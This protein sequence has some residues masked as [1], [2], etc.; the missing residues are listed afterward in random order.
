MAL[1]K[2]AVPT[3]EL[4]LPLSKKKITFRPFLVKE[5][6]IL[7]MAMESGEKD[8]MERAVKQILN[9]CTITELDINTI[10]LVDVE[11]YFLNLRARSIGEV[12]DLKYKCENEVDNKKCGHLMETKVNLLEIKVDGLD[13]YKDIV[14][15]VDNIGIKFKYPEFS[16][17][18]KLNNVESASDVAFELIAG[19]I[20]YV[21]DGDSLNYANESTKEE[22]IAFLQSLDSKSFEK[23]DAYFENLPSMK[24][25][26]SMTCGKCGFKHN[27]L[28]QGIEQLF[29]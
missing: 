6:K 22:L 26:L 15:L 28:V 1:P 4:E 27:I 20:E 19:C 13:T 3:Y 8:S 18:E 12:V 9:N 23:I 11:F 2:I 7:M 5:Q 25:V 14:P 24:K 16:V 29:G 17:I 21:Y 10:P